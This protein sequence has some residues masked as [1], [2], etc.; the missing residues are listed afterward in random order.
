MSKNLSFRRNRRLGT[1]AERSFRRKIT[2]YLLAACLLLALIL[3]VARLDDMR[4]ITRSGTP[5]V[6]DGDSLTIDG[7]RIRLWGIDAPE[8]HQSCTIKGEHY[9]CGRKARDVL[10]FRPQHSWRKYVKTA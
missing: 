4:S 6:N 7:L 9:P 5:A 10:G 1:V 8:L 2:D 3:A